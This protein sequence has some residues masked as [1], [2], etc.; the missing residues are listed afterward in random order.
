M[1]AM[2]AME[3]AVYDLN[4]LNKISYEVVGEALKV[5]SKLGPGLL[6]S[7]YEVC[8][9]HE[10]VKKGYVFETLRFLCYHCL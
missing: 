7:V 4:V 9:I 8:P 1:N 2:E 5:N 6:E 3:A 10:L